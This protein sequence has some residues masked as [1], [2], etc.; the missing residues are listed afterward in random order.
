MPARRKATLTIS[1][2][3]AP[4]ALVTTPMTRT[5]P[6]GSGRFF[7]ASNSPSAASLRLSCSSASSSAPRPAGR[8]FSAVNWSRPRG[9]YGTVALP[10]EHHPGPV[11]EE[12][13][14]PGRAAVRY[15]THSI[16]ASSRSRP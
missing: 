4:S 9:A 10:R 5:A 8:A 6:A 15:I 2:M 13:P 16:A 11:G 7:S 3:A 12:A 14:G 1:W